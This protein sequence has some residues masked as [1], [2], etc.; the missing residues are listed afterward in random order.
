MGA[1]FWV[2]EQF[3]AEGTGPGVKVLCPCPHVES[4]YDPKA[5]VS[6]MAVNDYAT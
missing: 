2:R 3:V 4:A 5:A 6:C 1:S